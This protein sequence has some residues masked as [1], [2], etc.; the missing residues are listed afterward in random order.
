VAA[1]ETVRR[2]RRRECARWGGAAGSAAAI[3]A[4]GARVG[5]YA[6][7]IES[8]DAALLVTLEPGA[9]TAHVSGASGSRGLVLVEVYDADVP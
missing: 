7:P 6:W 1:D 2:P 5:A 9:Y 3:Q 8:R 4:A